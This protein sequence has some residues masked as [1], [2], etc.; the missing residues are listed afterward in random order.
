[1]LS[2]TD[3]GS[4]DSRVWEV[5][6]LGF[7]GLGVV[8]D[9]CIAMSSFSC[10]VFQDWRSRRDVA[11]FLSVWFGFECCWFCILLILNSYFQV[12]RAENG[13]ARTVV[14]DVKPGEEGDWRVVLRMIAM[15]G[16]R[17]V[18]Q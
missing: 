5:V 7:R 1:M 9:V 17:D 14:R 11:F 10:F 4:V 12:G 16:W 6:E 8:W 2:K 18:L 3:V 13:I 15:R